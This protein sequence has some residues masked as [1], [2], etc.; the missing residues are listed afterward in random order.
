MILVAPACL[1]AAVSAVYFD[2][3]IALFAP[4]E[5]LV[6]F[7]TAVVPRIIAVYRDYHSAL[8]G[9]LVFVCGKLKAVIAGSV[10]Y[11]RVPAGNHYP[12]VGVF[13]S[14]RT[15]RINKDL[16]VVID[17]GVVVGVGVRAISSVEFLVHALED[18]VLVIVCELFCDLLPESRVLFLDV[19][20]ILAVAEEPASVDRVVAVTVN[21]DYH[22]QVVLVAVVNDFLNAVKPRLVNLVT[23][24]VINKA[25]IRNRNA[26]C[27]E[28]CC[29]Y[30]VYHFL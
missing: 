30:S 29:G 21:V 28:A 24:L 1:A 14:C 23:V 27:L 19:V 9:G 4:E 17:V 11:I 13:R 12:A 22:E 5:S 20:L 7:R 26:D 10:S 16:I 25:E 8:I 15:H 3:L 2:Y 18:E 6:V